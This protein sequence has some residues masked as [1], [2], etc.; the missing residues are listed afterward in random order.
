MGEYPDRRHIGFHMIGKKTILIFKY[1]LS[2]FVSEH[3]R[4]F[5][6]KP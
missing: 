6:S 2:E 3:D 1:R 5:I 4:N